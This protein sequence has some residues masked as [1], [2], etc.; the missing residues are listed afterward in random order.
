MV[1]NWKLCRQTVKMEISNKSV[2][3]TMAGQN[4]TTILCT[5]THTH[6]SVNTVPIKLVD[7]WS[8]HSSSNMVASAAY[9]E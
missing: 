4:L 1:K 3:H 2:R 5:H 9:N 8:P 6:N 7:E